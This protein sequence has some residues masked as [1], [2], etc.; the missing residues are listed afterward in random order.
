MLGL[1]EAI[2]NE[3]ILIAYKKLKSYVYHE[4]FSLHLR[5]QIANYK[6]PDIDEKLT[7]LRELLNK[8]S[9][10][11]KKA[12]QNYFS[13]ISVHLMP[14]A[15][16]NQNDNIDPSDAFYFSNANKQKNYLVD[17]CTPFINCPVELHIICMLL[18]TSRAHA[19]TIIRIVQT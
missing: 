12:I 6:S 15:F 4:N 8:Y 7:K 9:V 2:K 14:K 13:H 11:K 5:I 1:G 18:T 19:Q 16:H 10:G 17:S 3:D